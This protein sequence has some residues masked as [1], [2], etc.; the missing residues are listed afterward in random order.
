MSPLECL[1]GR[2]SFG[3]TA[4]VKQLGD[5]SDEHRRGTIPRGAGWCGDGGGNVRGRA[6]VWDEPRARALAA[7]EPAAAQA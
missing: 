6:R 4:K 7:A 3:A 2:A 5:D 1:E